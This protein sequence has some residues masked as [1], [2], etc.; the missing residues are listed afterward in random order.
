MGEDALESILDELHELLLVGPLVLSGRAPGAAV[1]HLGLLVVDLDGEV[2]GEPPR[3]LGVQLHLKLGEV[4]L[5]A[6][7]RQLLRSSH[8]R[9]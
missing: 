1:P 4:L 9:K 3:L 2:E 7:G 8:M 5:L 6:D